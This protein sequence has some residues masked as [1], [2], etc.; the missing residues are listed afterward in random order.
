MAAIKHLWKPLNGCHEASMDV[1][2][3]CMDIIR[4]YEKGPDYPRHHFCLHV[5]GKIDEVEISWKCE[6]NR[7]FK[8]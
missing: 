7:E 3:R 1:Q 2:W 5:G 6:G 4:N 8:K